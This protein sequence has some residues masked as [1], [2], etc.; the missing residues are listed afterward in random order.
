MGR[1]SWS[2]AAAAV[3]MNEAAQAEKGKRR[4][5]SVSRTYKTTILFFS[6]SSSSLTSFPFTQWKV[7]LAF[8]LGAMR[9]GCWIGAY[10]APSSGSRQ[11]FAQYFLQ[12]SALRIRPI[13]ILSNFVLQSSVKIH[14]S[15]LWKR[16]RLTFLSAGPK[17]RERERA[18]T[19]LFPSSA[20]QKIP[21]WA[22]ENFPP[23]WQSVFAKSHYVQKTLSPLL[24]RRE[25]ESR[26]TLN[27]EMRDPRSFFHSPSPSSTNCR[28]C[29]TVMVNLVTSN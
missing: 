10:K 21:F 5:N 3:A 8:R 4:Y 20:C 15:L 18:T 12:K 24:N 6:S 2:P 23:S 16:I 17:R 26:L 14:R 9:R 22:A 27:L 7:Q 1:I 19:Y 29:A 28:V 11:S 13:T 25:E